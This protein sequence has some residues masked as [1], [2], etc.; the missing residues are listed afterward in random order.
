M[1]SPRLVILNADLDGARVDVTLSGPTI[2]SIVPSRRATRHRT[3][4]A[5]ILDAAGGGLLPGLHD[6]H[7]HLLALAAA[8]SSLDAGPPAVTNAAQLFVA[9]R[10]LHAKLGPNDWIRAVGYHESVAGDIDRSWLDA[11]G[12]NRPIRV[13]HR[14]GALWVLNSAA[15]DAIGGESVVAPLTEV[16][17]SGRSSG[18]LFRRDDW[19]GQRTPRQ[20]I[21]L[22]ATASRLCAYGLTGVTDLTP[23][24][25]PHAL[26][27]LA[28]AIESGAV[29]FGV[30][31]TGSPDLPSGALPTLPRGP[32]KIVLDDF[33]LPPFDQL[34]DTIRRIHSL[35]RP[36]AIH[37]VS[38][39]TLAFV[40]A[41]WREAGSKPGDRLEHGAIVPPDF[42]GDL[43]AHGITVVTQPSFLHDRG[44]EYLAAVEP[45][46]Q[47]HLW[48]CGS[49][50]DAGIPVVFGSD[51]P[52][53]DPDPWATIRTAVQRRTRDGAA[54]GVDEAVDARTALNLFLGTATEPTSIRRVAAGQPSDL[55]VLNRTLRDQLADPDESG[56]AAS[57]VRGRVVYTRP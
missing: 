57:V 54:L 33:D 37:C 18:R 4:G 28:D 27:A 19:L 40:V 14:S 12:I 52:F 48:R 45:R 20:P 51:A 3:A 53:G 38:R 25:E 34:V 31:I 35:R 24:A 1:T 32:A 44:D 42:F 15:I 47:P 39:S 43:A 55:C 29:P 2:E 56:V 17:A 21:D 13:Q 46:D 6:H 7:I 41:V 5:E 9:L 26:T 11:L 49:L 36:V 23:T 8:D 30:T 22:R 16:D 50:I 10:R